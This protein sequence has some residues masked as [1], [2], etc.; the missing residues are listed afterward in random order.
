MKR[1]NSQRVAGGDAFKAAYC[2]VFLTI[3]DVR[4]LLEIIVLELTSVRLLIV[5]L[6]RDLQSHV[7]RSPARLCMGRGFHFG[8]GIYGRV[9]CVLVYFNSF[10]F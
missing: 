4:M 9:D 3:L 1:N 6:V 2:L 7:D 5:S 10:V 8:V